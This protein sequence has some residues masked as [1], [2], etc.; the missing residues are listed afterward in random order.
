MYS[1]DEK[2][3]NYTHSFDSQDDMKKAMKE[4]KTITKININAY[5][6]NFD[7]DSFENMEKITHLTITF[8][9][10][11]PYEND[12]CYNSCY[13]LCSKIFTRF[14]GVKYLRIVNYV[15][16]GFMSDDEN[17]I[18]MF[19]AYD[20]MCLSKLETLVI[21]S[22][23]GIFSDF[24]FFRHGNL[25]NLVFISMIEFDSTCHDITYIL[26]KL[27]TLRISFD[28]EGVDKMLRSLT[29]IKKLSLDNCYCINDISNFRKLKEIEI[30]SCGDI[31]RVKEV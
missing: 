22:S 5:N 8:G 11:Q 27:E 30:I 29:H 31:K 28:A 24:K 15:N 20:L 2:E 16:S 7:N 21:E 25:K 1:Y 18:N 10:T 3:D 23:M 14:F 12:D 13:T 19:S 6:N 17:Q 9:I 26:P 4:D